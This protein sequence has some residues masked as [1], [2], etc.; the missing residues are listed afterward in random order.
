M[1]MH[2]LVKQNDKFLH[3]NWRIIVIGT[4]LLVLTVRNAGNSCPLLEKIWQWCI[5]LW[6]R[7]LSLSQLTVV[8]QAS[9]LIIQ[10]EATLGA[11]PF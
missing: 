10:S 8:K 11:L 9:T 2:S 5:K 3:W 7:G 1:E 4:C 6:W